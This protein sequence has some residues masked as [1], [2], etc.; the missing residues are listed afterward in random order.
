M[1]H[2]ALGDPLV[3]SCETDIRPIAYAEEFA[4]AARRLLIPQLEDEAPAPWIESA[5]KHA[6]VASPNLR[7]ALEQLREPGRT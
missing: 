3:W 2:P 7:E 4:S 1:P 6:N 5:R